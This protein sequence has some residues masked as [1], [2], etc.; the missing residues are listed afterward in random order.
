MRSMGSVTAWRLAISSAR[1][2]LRPV[3][4]AAG[5]IG[6]WARGG[7]IDKFL[8]ECHGVIHIGANRAQERYKYAAHG[9]SVVWIEAIPSLCDDILSN[10]AQFEKQRLIQALIVDEDGKDCLLHV[11]N[12]DGGSSSILELKLHRKLWPNVEFVSQLHLK[13]ST[14]P[15]VLSAAGIDPSGYDAIV[16]DIQGAE[17]MALKGALP[18]LKHIRYIQTEAADFESYG[19]CA[20]VSQLSEFLATCGFR[21][22]RKEVFAGRVGVGFYYELLFQRL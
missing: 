8:A 4:R 22:L 19:G 20:S 7:S 21:L 11:A 10:I 16:L 1:R 2:Y 6:L 18:I 14:L 3:K 9:L 17:L 13:S 5:A 12:N 15:T